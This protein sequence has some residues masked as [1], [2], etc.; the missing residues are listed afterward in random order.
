MEQTGIWEGTDKAYSA[1]FIRGINRSL[2]RTGV[3][4]F[5]ILTF[6]FPPYEAI[7]LPSDPVYPDSYAPNLIADP[8]FGPDAALGFSGGDIAPM[9]PGSRFR[10]FDY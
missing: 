5:E 2:A 8:T 9:I 3:G 10:V 4:A 7:F 6:P 1:G